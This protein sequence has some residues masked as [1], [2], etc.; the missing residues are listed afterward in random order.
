PYNLRYKLT[1]NVPDGYTVDPASLEQLQVNKATRCGSYFVQTKYN[2]DDRTL[3]IETNHRN[4]RRLYQASMWDEY[5]DLRD[6]A[7]EF[8]NATVV[9]TAE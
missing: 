6:A 4:N 7:I 1:I 5:L 2:P 9:L 3:T 8:S